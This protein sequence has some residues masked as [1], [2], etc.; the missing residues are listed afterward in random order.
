VKWSIDWVLNKFCIVVKQLGFISSRLLLNL[1]SRPLDFLLRVISAFVVFLFF[2]IT[3]LFSSIT[4]TFNLILN[5]IFKPLFVLVSGV[6]D[7]FFFN[8]KPVTRTT[9]FLFH[10]YYLLFGSFI[11]LSSFL[12]TYLYKLVI[13]FFFFDIPRSSNKIKNLCLGV[14]KLFIYFV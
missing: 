4:F 11:N 1:L 6:I 14:L 2:I 10:L 13:D 8:F 3:S 12:F 9:N 7:G 5:V